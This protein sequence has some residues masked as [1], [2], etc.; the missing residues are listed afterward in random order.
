MEVSLPV[1][2]KNICRVWV[3]PTLGISC[4]SHLHFDVRNPETQGGKVTQ[5]VGFQR[6]PRAW[7]LGQTS[8]LQ[9][10]LPLDSFQSGDGIGWGGYV[11][12]QPKLSALGAMQVRQSLSLDG[13]VCQRPLPTHW[14]CCR[15][16]ETHK[17]RHLCP[18]PAGQLYHLLSCCSIARRYVRQ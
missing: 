9:L 12:R 11:A 1:R 16:M 17:S 4:H 10:P 7:F 18:V 6:R 15:D 14:S 3:G 8:F 13:L 2:K 5:L